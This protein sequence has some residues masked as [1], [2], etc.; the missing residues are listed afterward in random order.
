[1]TKIDAYFIQDLVHNVFALLFVLHASS[2]VDGI[3]HHLL[4]LVHNV[5]L[6]FKLH[7]DALQ[8][9]QVHLPVHA[10]KQCCMLLALIL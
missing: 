7:G 9:W 6:F 10:S 1:M 4:S 8:S 5:V 2:I 3:I